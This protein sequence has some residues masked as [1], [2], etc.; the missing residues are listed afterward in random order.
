MDIDE[1]VNL[2][3]AERSTTLELSM[4]SGRSYRLPPGARAYDHGSDTLL[5]LWPAD[6][7]YKLSRSVYIGGV[8]VS[9][10]EQVGANPSG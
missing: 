5:L 1:L 8:N 7:P 2:I 3:N 9:S 4:N 10:V 6:V